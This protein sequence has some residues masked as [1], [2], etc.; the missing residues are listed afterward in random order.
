[1]RAS[2]LL[3]AVLGYVATAAAAAGADGLRLADALRLALAQNP[4]LQVEQAQAAQAH[5]LA[6]QAEGSFDTLL[7]GGAD[8]TRELSVPPFGPP[9]GKRVLGTGYQL[10]AAR[11]L[12]SGV[13]LSA[14]LDAAA[15]QDSALRA[16]QQQGG[17]ARLGVTLALPLLRG[18]GAGE[19]AAGEDSAR[20]AAQAARALLRHRAAQV[21]QDT[22]AA[23]WRYSIRLALLEVASSSAERAGSLLDST[24]KLVAASQRPRA[25]LVLLEADLADKTGARQAAELAVAEA[26]HALGLLMGLDGAASAALGRPLDTLPAVAEL[27]PVA[28]AGL[29]QQALARR[30][31]VQALAAQVAG[32][33]R[34]LQGARGQLRP[35]LDLELGA[36]YA[37]V[38][39]GA[40]HYGFLSDPA[41]HPDGPSLGARLRYEF[42]LRNS[43][44]QGAYLARAAEL[45]SLQARQKGLGQEVGSGVEFALQALASSA[46]Q[47]RVA[48]RAMGLYEQAVRQEMVKQANGIATLIDVINVEGRFVNARTSLL[49]TQLAYAGALARLRFE[50]GT[51]LPA[52]AAPER[53]ELDAGELASLGPLAPQLAAP[54]NP[55]PPPPP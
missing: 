39:A 13:R 37:R 34:L 50:T 29:A 24:R 31:D 28:P 47:L 33:E 3:L 19:V 40:S 4:A 23:Y 41:R 42:P 10:G 54:Q 49:N 21:L 45:A 26:R 27:A 25:D 38:T 11:Q 6:L 20:L 35:R 18:R 48:Q 36:S 30:D 51:L 9:A 12:R 14:G 53:F 32:A 1:M 22:L 8:Y 44:A 43:A 16:D 46:A 5:G 17:T 15:Y 52:G 2:K 7:D 55:S